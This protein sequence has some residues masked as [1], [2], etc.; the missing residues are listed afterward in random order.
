MSEKKKP[1]ASA[2]QCK[3]PGC[4]HNPSKF[5]FCTSHFDQF[6]FGLINKNGEPCM[7]YDKK[8]D[9]YEHATGRKVG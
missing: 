6:K 7:D 4:K 3:K 9:Q 5:G 1:E 8:L 2:V